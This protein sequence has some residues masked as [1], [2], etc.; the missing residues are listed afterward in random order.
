M[1]QRALSTSFAVPS[2]EAYQCSKYVEFNRAEDVI[3]TPTSF[4]NLNHRG[5]RL[6]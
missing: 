6:L 3:F 2:M 4:S 1:M 5:L